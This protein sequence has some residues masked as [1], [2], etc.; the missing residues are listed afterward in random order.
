MK[1]QSSA[2]ASPSCVKR[3]LGRCGRRAVDARR[4]GLEQDRRRRRQPGRD[5]ILHHLVLAVDGDDLAR[6]QLGKSMW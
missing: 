1:S 2:A 5:Q 3:I 6:R 4:L